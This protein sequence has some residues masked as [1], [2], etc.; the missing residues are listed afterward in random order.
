MAT[1]TRSW[2]A[3]CARSDSEGGVAGGVEGGGS[4]G[5]EGEGA[6]PP[7]PCESLSGRPLSLVKVNIAGSGIDLVKVRN[8]HGRNE[9]RVGNWGDSSDVSG[10][11]PPP[12]ARCAAQPCLA[13]G[14]AIRATPSF[15][16]LVDLQGRAGG[17]RARGHHRCG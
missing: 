13:D 11:P 12:L 2:R 3:R 6:A 8:P 1:L 15:A 9:I 5:G 7:A 17:L 16:E 10:R 14:P 4:D